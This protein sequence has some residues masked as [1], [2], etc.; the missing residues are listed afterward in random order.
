MHDQTAASFFSPNYGF[1]YVL[2]D[3]I[4]L[5]YTFESLRKLTYLTHFSISTLKIEDDNVS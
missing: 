5:I 4:S 1:D 2:A 3:L